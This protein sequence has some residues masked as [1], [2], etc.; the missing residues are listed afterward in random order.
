MKKLLALFGVAALSIQG[1]SGIITIPKDYPLDAAN[2]GK[3]TKKEQ[4]AMLVSQY[5][6]DVV[7]LANP[8]D[9]FSQEIQDTAPSADAVEKLRSLATAGG[10]TLT[11]DSLASAVTAMVRLNPN[12]GSV[13]L[14]SAMEVVKDLPGA[15]S[16]ENRI[17]LGRAAIRGLP[18]GED[19][20]KQTSM[21]IGTSVRGL[22]QMASTNIIRELRDFA[23]GE[24]SAYVLD[25]ALVD[26]GIL[27]AYVGSPEFLVMADNFAAD[28]LDETFFS[29]DQGTINQGG[30]YAPGGQG[31][32]GGSGGTGSQSGGS[33]PTPTP[34]PPAS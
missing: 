31:S 18:E 17:A 26:A 10:S 23:I 5:Q 25:Q 4:L 9:S 8:F 32:A 30:V 15:F 2:V 21:I 16:Y 12:S 11:V 22:K 19:K 13:I 20:A 33:T 3:A 29:G 7:L 34:P 6:N 1:A 27:S 28:Q 24:G 14:A